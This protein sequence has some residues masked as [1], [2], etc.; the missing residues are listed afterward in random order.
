MADEDDYEYVYSDSDGNE[1]AAVG[2]SSDACSHDNES[3]AGWSDGDVYSDDNGSTASDRPA[4]S[5]GDNPIDVDASSQPGGQDGHRAATGHP[6]AR[7]WLHG[8]ATGLCGIATRM[9]SQSQPSQPTVPAPLAGEDPPPPAPAPAKTRLTFSGKIPNISKK[10]Y[11]PI[12]IY[13]QKK[14]KF[15]VM[16]A[17][18]T[19][20]SYLRESIRQLMTVPG[21]AAQHY[22]LKLFPGNDDHKNELVMHGKETVGDLGLCTGEDDQMATSMDLYVRFDWKHQAT[23]EPHRTSKRSSKPATMA[24]MAEE[25]KLENRAKRSA[26]RSRSTKKAE[27]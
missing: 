27:Y 7:S 12:N 4:A 9:V 11:Q 1:S 21:D 2:S 16:V 5:Y 17:P 23:M 8:D 26:N 22:E 3:A 10:N 6:A 18:T 15:S 13:Q 24:K 25:I 14:A 19:P 20:L